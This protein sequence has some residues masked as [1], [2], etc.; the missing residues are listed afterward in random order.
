MQISGAGP[1]YNAFAVEYYQIV[2]NKV[3]KMKVCPA[4][5]T[6]YTDDTLSFCLQDGRPLTDAVRED[7]PTAAFGEIETQVRTVSGEQELDSHVTRVRGREPVKRGRLLLA[8]GITA[9]SMLAIFS[10]VGVV[11]YILWPGRSSVGSANAPNSEVNDPIHI[12]PTRPA[13]A[14]TPGPTVTVDPT[15]S[16]TAAA[17]SSPSPG[18]PLIED[19]IS[20]T[21]YD[22]K[23]KLES[24]DL[25]AYMRNYDT[26]VDYFRRR[27]VSA[28]TVRADKARA[29]ALYDSMNVGISNLSVAVDR[30]GD[31]AKATFD[32]EWAFSGRG[33]SEGKVRSEVRFRLVNGR[34]LIT[35]ERDLKVY[36]TR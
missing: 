5:Q 27:G 35:S 17:T 2:P 18:K 22:W 30:A 31:T 15:P 9:F 36:Y 34:W 4:C 7:A 8:V 1:I 20:Q 28:A 33:K 16:R 6:Q 21:V 26:T 29:F 10:I 24:R 32:K 23:S 25:N 19:D 14:K 12:E 3:R 11:G 13:P